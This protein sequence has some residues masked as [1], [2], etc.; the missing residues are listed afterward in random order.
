MGTQ[1]N[2]VAKGATKKPTN[3]QQTKKADQQPNSTTVKVE[4]ATKSAADLARERLEKRNRL[5]S[6]YQDIEQLREAKEDFDTIQSAGEVRIVVWC[7]GSQK[8]G[9]HREDTVN[10]ALQAIKTSIEAKLKKAEED[11]AAFQ[12]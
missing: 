2:G 6:L 9:T 1:T 12:F 5:E 4:E 7:G 8:F 11:L 10:S 3:G